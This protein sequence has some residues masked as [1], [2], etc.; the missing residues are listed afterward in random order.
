[1]LVASQIILAVV[2][3]VTTGLLVAHLHRQALTDAARAQAGLAYLVGSAVI[4]EAVVVSIGMLMLRQ[5]HGQRMLN[6]GRAAGAEAEAVVGNSRHAEMFGM[7]ASRI[8]PGATVDTLLRRA[9]GESNLSRSD[10]QSRLR[11]IQQLKVARK[12]VAVVRELSDGRTLA[13]NFVPVED[14]GWLVT[15]EDITERRV[16]AG[17]S[18]QPSVS[19]RRGGG[20]MRN[21]VRGGVRRDRNL[22]RPQSRRH[23]GRCAGFGT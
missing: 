17:L 2:I 14:D 13:I 3:A 19:G 11:S 1:L 6:E 22:T 10:V 5:L 9:D 8:T 15:F 16:G 18:V 23:I 12:R 21:V 4:L 20:A 7:P